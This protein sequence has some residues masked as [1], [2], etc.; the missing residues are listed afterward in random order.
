MSRSKW[1]EFHSTHSS[2]SIDKPKEAGGSTNLAADW[3]R[4]AA[5]TKSPDQPVNVYIDGKPLSDYAENYNNFAN[6]SDVENFFKEVLMEKMKKPVQ[7]EAEVLSFFQKTLHQGGLLYP[8][9]SALSVA[10]ERDAT[11]EEADASHVHNGRVSEATVGATVQTINIIPIEEG[12]KIQEHVTVQNIIVS[13]QYFDKYGIP[14]QTVTF[15]NGEVSIEAEESSIKKEDGSPVI[16]AQGEVIVNCLKSEPEIS[17]GYNAITYNDPRI[18]KAMDN[19]SLGQIFIDYLK[20]AFGLNKVEE[21]KIKSEE[22]D[23]ENQQDLPSDLGMS[24]SQ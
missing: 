22:N 23:A 5:S 12:I 14:Y 18:E 2:L 7:N 15:P 17:I 13:E 6:K 9:T 19:R 3:R 4:A 16:E 1:A 8:V 24:N 20:R 10:M 11:A 21:I